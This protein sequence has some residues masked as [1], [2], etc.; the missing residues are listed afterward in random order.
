MRID[1]DVVV[2]VAFIGGALLIGFFIA[3]VIVK[4]RGE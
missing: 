3:V 2:T 1:H 4:L